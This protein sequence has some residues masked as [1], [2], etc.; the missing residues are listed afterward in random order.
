MAWGQQPTLLAKT[1][2]VPTVPD[3]GQRLTSPAR[4]LSLGQRVRTDLAALLHDPKVVFLDE[5]TIS[6]EVSVKARI[7][8]F[9]RHANREFG[10]TLLLTAH[11]LGGAEM[12][13]D[14]VITIV[15]GQL[16][17]GGVPEQLRRD[18]RRGDRVTLVASRGSVAP[19]KADPRVAR[20]LDGRK[21]GSLH[22][23]VCTRRVRTS[24]LVTRTLAPVPAEDLQLREARIT[25]VLWELYDRGRRD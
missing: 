22:G 19:L 1:G 3:R 5:P 2:V 21:A 20:H 25:D 24:D 6:L 10:A 4:K 16:V 14:R 17:F 9:R 13:S 11:H 15:E 8:E 7:R 23:G 12:S 18:L